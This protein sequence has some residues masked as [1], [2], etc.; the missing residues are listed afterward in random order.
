MFSSVLLPQPLGPIRETTSPSP[1]ATL[2]SFT[3]STDSVAPRAGKRLETPRNSMRGP[4]GEEVI[5][6]GRRVSYMNSLL[7]YETQR[8]IKNVQRSRKSTLPVDHNPFL[9]RPSR[10]A[11]DSPAKG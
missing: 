3:A 2:T 10:P 1:T 4:A 7:A 5:G 6:R 9:A 11:G 8:S